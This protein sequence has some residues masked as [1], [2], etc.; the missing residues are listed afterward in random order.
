MYFRRS[1]YALGELRPA[2]FFNANPSIAQPEDGHTF[3]WDGN[4]G[5]FNGL[6]KRNY[7]CRHRYLS[8]LRA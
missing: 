5:D 3:A 2:T 1:F 6:T 7:P 4:M 8:F